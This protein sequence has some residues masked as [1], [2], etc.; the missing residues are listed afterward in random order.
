MKGGPPGKTNSKNPGLIWDKCFELEDL[1]VKLRKRVKIKCVGEIS[2]P[3]LTQ[4]E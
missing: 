3:S 1:E 4:K 2:L